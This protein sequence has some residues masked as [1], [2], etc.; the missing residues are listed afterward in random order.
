MQINSKILE[1]QNGNQSP[2]SVCLEMGFS[3]EAGNNGREMRGK[4]GNIEPSQPCDSTDCEP[5]VPAGSQT[6]PELLS[7][8]LNLAE[9]RPQS[10]VR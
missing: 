1:D 5:P 9:R 2:C 7:K 3:L 6:T 4:V 10:G 8:D